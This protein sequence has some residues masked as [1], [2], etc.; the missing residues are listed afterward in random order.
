M[1]DD[2][3]IARAEAA[4]EAARERLIDTVQ[5]IALQLEPRRLIGELWEDAKNKGADLAEEAVDAVKARP[6]AAT[7]VVAA[8]AMF[9]AREPIAD[10]AGKMFDGFGDKKKRK[11]EAKKSKAKKPE[12]KQPNAKKR[13][14]KKP[15]VRKPAK[16]KK[17]EES[18]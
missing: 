18:K 5:D 12:G 16:S 14:P 10:L 13:A 4:V 3:K 17:V 2:P 1:T 9:L 11:L 8:I 7:G 15:A 6:L